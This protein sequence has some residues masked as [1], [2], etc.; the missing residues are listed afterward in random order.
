VDCLATGP[1]LFTYLPIASFAIALAGLLVRFFV[2][3]GP[4]RQTA[5]VATLLFMVLAS[6][7]IWQQDH[8][9]KEQIEQTADDIVR[10][11]G[12]QKLTYEQIVANTR[13]PTYLTTN[14]GIDLLLR[15][16]RIGTE[17]ATLTDR[18]S[19]KAYQITL[20]FVRTF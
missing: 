1:S 5:V 18:D 17:L 7:V 15:Q 13:N 10:I 2:P 3:V 9:C 20:F 8:K 16:K 4:A 14:A 19:G 11:L 12:N 6:A